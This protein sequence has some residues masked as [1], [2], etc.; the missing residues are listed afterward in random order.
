MP[1][2][3]ARV[4]VLNVISLF[5]TVLAVQGN[6]FLSLEELEEYCEVVLDK[7]ITLGPIKVHNSS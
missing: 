7:S 5:D 4:S 1:P 2:C 3:I 6:T